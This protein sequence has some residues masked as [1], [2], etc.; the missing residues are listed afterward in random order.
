MQ[1]YYLRKT[2]QVAKVAEQRPASPSST[3]RSIALTRWRQCA[4]HLTHASFCSVHA[5]LPPPSNGIAIG[6]AVFAGLL[7]VTNT[8]TYRQKD[9]ATSRHVYE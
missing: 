6:S 5:S 9:H 4:P 3:D 1:Q 8:E 7:H 2:H